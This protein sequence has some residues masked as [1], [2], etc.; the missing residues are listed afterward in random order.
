MPAGVAPV[1][2]H[3]PVL[4]ATHGAPASSG[5]E[6]LDVGGAPTEPARPV[7]V[8]EREAGEPALR[9]A[10]G[11]GWDPQAASSVIAA[12]TQPKSWALLTLAT[13]RHRLAQRTIRRV[14]SD[15]RGITTQRNALDTQP[16]RV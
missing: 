9:K 6:V 2:V 16:S 8:V 15:A 11:T 1:P 12:S 5:A 4:D 13:L 10:R 14:T 7:E 3:T